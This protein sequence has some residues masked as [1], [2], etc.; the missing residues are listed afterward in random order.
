MMNK[1]VHS[2]DFTWAMC[3]V[4]IW[5]CVEPFIGIL[6]A[7]LPTYAPLVRH[8]YSV[9]GSQNGK[10]QSFSSYYKYP[11]NK[12]NPNKRFGGVLDTT[13][14]GGDEIEFRTN[15]GGAQANAGGKGYTYVVHS[16]SGSTHKPESDQDI[17]VRTD[18]SFSSN[19]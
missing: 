4:F 18:F 2:A 19:A 17:L 9:S 1:L 15:T 3:Q 14:H 13:V 8:W 12:P 7:C 5:S 11:A 6:C 10:G 16:S